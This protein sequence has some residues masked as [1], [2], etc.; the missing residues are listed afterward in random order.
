MLKQWSINLSGYYIVKF[1]KKHILNMRF[2]DIFADAF[3]EG[4]DSFLKNHTI[5]INFVVIFY[6][7]LTNSLLSI[8]RVYIYIDLY[9]KQY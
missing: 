5:S 9:K 6:K 1:Q 4:A 3:C 7:L 2:L 8:L